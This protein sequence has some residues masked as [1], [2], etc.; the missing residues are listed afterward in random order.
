MPGWLVR[1]RCWVLTHDVRLHSFA[2][3]G[4]AKAVR[5]AC[6]RPGCT[7]HQDIEFP[8]VRQHDRR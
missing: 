1:L 2:Q 6:V 5:Y 4:G 7:Y 3:Y 8:P